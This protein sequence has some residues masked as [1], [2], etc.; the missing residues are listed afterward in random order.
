[1]AKIVLGKRPKSFK[2]K[3]TF[4]MLDGTEGMV[5]MSFIYRTRT[6]FGA[7]ID[8]LMSDAGV[9]KSDGVSLEEAMTKTRDSNAE[10]I[11]K[12]ADGWDL[13]QPFNVDTAAQLCDEI[14]AAAIA[15]M[16]AYRTAITEGRL[17]N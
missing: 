15:I 16:T 1:M 10:Y 4:G 8:G 11:L 7:L 2:C 6:E 3:V 5:E 14:P 12:V 9:D 13:D 17:G